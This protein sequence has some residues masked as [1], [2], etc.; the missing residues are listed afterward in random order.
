MW[1]K[2]ILEGSA[3]FA[4]TVLLIKIVNNVLILCK[5]ASINGLTLGLIILTC[6]ILSTIIKN[7]AYELMNKEKY[8]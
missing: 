4:L 6:F 7:F 8:E 2:S 5:V 1:I 3:T